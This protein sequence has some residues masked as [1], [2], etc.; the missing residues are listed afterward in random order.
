MGVNVHHRTQVFIQLLFDE[1]DFI[2]AKSLISWCS[3][4]E[5]NRCF[6]RERATS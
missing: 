5:S 4:A 6:R 1:L 2:F 3:L